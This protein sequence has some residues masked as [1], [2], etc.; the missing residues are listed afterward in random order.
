VNPRPDLHD[1]VLESFTFYWETGTL[2][3]KFG[4]GVDDT[5]VVIVECGGVERI[6]C[7]RLLPWGPSDFV[8]S[9]KQEPRQNGYL[10][11]IEMQSG[12]LSE[13]FCGTVIRKG[14]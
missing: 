4:I 9:S 8:N 6:S 5:D 7:P 1:A 3:I 2:L 10:L 12:D 11:T 14:Q 13:I